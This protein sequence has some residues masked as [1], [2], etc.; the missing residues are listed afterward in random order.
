M[1][2]TERVLTAE[3]WVLAAELKQ[4]G[5]YC[6]EV[7]GGGGGGVRIC[8]ANA[9]AELRS[10]EHSHARA[11]SHLHYMQYVIVCMSSSQ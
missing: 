2:A 10:I 8:S 9:T 1:F 3:K 6:R 5:A 7:G 4:V 11:V